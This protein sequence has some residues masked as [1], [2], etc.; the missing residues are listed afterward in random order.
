MAPIC[1]R[2]ARL[3]VF[4]KFLVVFHE[5]RE[6]CGARDSENDRS[7]QNED[8][9]QGTYC[10]PHAPIHPN[11]EDDV[12]CNEE[13]NCVA[14]ADVHGAVVEVRLGFEILVAYTATWVEFGH[15][16]ESVWI[17]IWIDISLHTTWTFTLGNAV[18][19]GSL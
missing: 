5:H 12:Y 14:V 13:G 10:R 18:D 1:L 2:S 15:G 8:Y 6:P 19:L 9:C 16:F 11:S 3:N 4:L 17:L 7:S